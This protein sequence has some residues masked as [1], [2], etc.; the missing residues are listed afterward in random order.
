[1]YK[2]CPVCRIYDLQSDGVTVYKRGEDGRPSPEIR[3]LRLAV[4]LDKSYKRAIAV[5]GQSK[6]GCV[7]ICNEC[8][9]RAVT[10][11]KELDSK[12]PV[13]APKPIE[14]AES[15]FIAER[16]LEI[17]MSKATVSPEHCPVCRKM[18]TDYRD[19]VLIVAARDVRVLQRATEL[20]IRYNVTV[21]VAKGKRTV[22]EICRECWLRAVVFTRANPFD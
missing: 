9:A 3:V 6:N 17:K 21:N 4:L 15:V 10:L 11:K 1:M 18:V 13:L 8:W 19:W 14:G 12:R 20:N 5:T 7:E 2:R 16:E 22:I